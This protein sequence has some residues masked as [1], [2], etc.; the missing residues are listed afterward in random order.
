M[1]VISTSVIFWYHS[2]AKSYISGLT[3]ETMR[4]RIKSYKQST[5]ALSG[6]PIS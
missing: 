2:C 1:P 4:A 3:N 6:Q 5:K